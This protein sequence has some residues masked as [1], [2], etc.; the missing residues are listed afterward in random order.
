MTIKQ[1]LTLF[2]FALA[3]GAVVLEAMTW[4]VTGRL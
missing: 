3:L 2:L 4:M 1:N